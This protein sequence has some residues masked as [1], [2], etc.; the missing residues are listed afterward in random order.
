V[1]RL[2]SIAIF[3]LTLV[4]AA[5]L[6]NFAPWQSSDTSP[7][8]LISGA[9]SPIAKLPQ[10][11]KL[12]PPTFDVVRVSPT[13]NT[14]IAG[15]AM[16]DSLVVN[17]DNGVEFGRIKAD[18]RGDWV[19]VPQKPLKPGSHTLRLKMLVGSEPPVM[20]VED[21]VVIVP[22]AGKD[23]AG[24]N[25]DGDIIALKM[26]PDG[27]S[28]VLQKPG[29]RSSIKLSIDSVDYD[30]DGRLSISGSSQPNAMVQIYLDNKLIGH[31]RSGEDKGEGQGTWTMNPDNPVETGLYTL[32]ADQIGTD[33]KVIQR[34]AFPFSRAEPTGKISDKNKIVVQPGNSLWRLA[35]SSYGKGN[36]YTIIFEA[37][38]DQIK[39]P[40]LI[41]PGQVFKLLKIKGK[42]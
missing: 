32:R 19:F 22:Q 35:R 18:D 27:S 24:R 26:N 39:D 15:R 28:T 12:E 20:S 9:P 17:L 6:L 21:V 4:A 23:I 30:D 42:N 36:Q 40:N 13:G 16:P 3:G 37:N 31:A 1:S 5:I 10:A 11:L 7:P 38:K 25:G 2:L 34:I 33:G 29:A 8:E 14:V 41:Y